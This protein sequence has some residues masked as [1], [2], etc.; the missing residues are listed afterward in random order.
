MANN[1]DETP[2]QVTEPYISPFMRWAGNGLRRD[3]YNLV[4]YP[5][6]GLYPS[7]RMDA[8]ERTDEIQAPSSQP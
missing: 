2:G 4:Y 1:A 3:E 5:P 8:A 7:P 6:L